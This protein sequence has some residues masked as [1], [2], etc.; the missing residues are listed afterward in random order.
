MKSSEGYSALQIA[1]H[2]SIAVLIGV[3]Y[4]V[5]EGM[6]DAF[7]GT[8]EGKA[9]TGLTPTVHVWVGVAVLVLVAVRIAVRLMRGAPVA[10]GTA[11]TILDLAAKGVHGLLYLLMIAVPVLGAVTWFGGIEATADL[12][13]LA[14]NAMMVLILA[15]AGAALFHHY[16]LRD[17]L[18][19][20]MIRAR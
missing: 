9:A 4:F 18:I 1:L 8:L 15:H 10:P 11:P 3:N 20:R 14:M 16:V 17:G 5:S 12:H 19:L 2:W 6:G 7:D 13:V